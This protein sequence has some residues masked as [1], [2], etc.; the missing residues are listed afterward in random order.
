M[1]IPRSHSF[2]SLLLEIDKNMPLFTM[3]SDTLFLAF[4]FGSGS[5]LIAKAPTAAIT[6][7]ASLLSSSASTAETTKAP[8]VHPDL[9]RRDSNAGTRTAFLAETN[10]CGYLNGASSQCLSFDH[11]AP[12]PHLLTWEYSQTLGLVAMSDTSRRAVYLSTTP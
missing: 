4:L 8:A 10:I 7:A 9:L 1:N 12:V 11:L 5:A 3:R 2:L 6:D